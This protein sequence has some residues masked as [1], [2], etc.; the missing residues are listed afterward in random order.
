MGPMKADLF[1][2]SEA[3]QPSFNKAERTG[4]PGR[5]KWPALF[6]SDTARHGLTSGSHGAQMSDP[7]PTC[8]AGQPPGRQSI[9]GMTQNAH[10]PGFLKVGSSRCSLVGGGAEGEQR[11]ENEFVGS[12]NTLSIASAPAWTNGMKQT[13]V[14]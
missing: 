8:Q 7:R 10:T 3:L 13:A 9:F 2:H 11:F 1:C 14:H 6:W 4:R 12:Y 5:R